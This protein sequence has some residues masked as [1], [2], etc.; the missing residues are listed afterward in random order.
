MH[1]VV[2]HY[3]EEGSDDVNGAEA[4]IAQCLQ[5]TSTSQRQCLPQPKAA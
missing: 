5:E 4:H 2:P 1:V 3:S